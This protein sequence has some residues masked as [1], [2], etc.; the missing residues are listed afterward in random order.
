M[1]NDQWQ[2]FLSNRKT[3][4]SFWLLVFSGFLSVALFSSFMCWNEGRLGYVFNDPILKLIPATDFSRVTMALTLIP[5]VF[6][7][8]VIFRHPKTTV[9]FFFTAIFICIL[10]TITLYLTPLDPPNGIIPLT[11][12]VIENLFYGGK[13]LLKDLFFSGHTANLVVIGLLL[14]NKVYQRI[15]F[16]C[17]TLV[18]I[19]LMV[20]HVHYSIDVFAAP[21]F[22]IFAYKM[23]VLSGDKS[24]FFRKND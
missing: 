23:A 17:A 18:G 24:I 8:I 5:I 16:I 1:L 22:A 12:P 10:R 11:D 21:I 6:G 15:L 19:L 14:E 13:V 20:Q 2:R 4:L 9:Y 7:I 3:A